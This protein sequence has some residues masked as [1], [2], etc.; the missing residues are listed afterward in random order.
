MHI[1]TYILIYIQT[2]SLLGQLV[3]HCCEE[4]A[5]DAAGSRSGRYIY[6]HVKHV[7]RYTYMYIH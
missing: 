1:H 2:A 6:T 7:Y 3:A 5:D 4:P